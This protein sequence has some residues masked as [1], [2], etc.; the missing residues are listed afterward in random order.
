[1]WWLGIPVAVWAAKK[2]YDAVDESSSSSSYSSNDYDEKAE[3]SER[4]AKRSLAIENARVT[5]KSFLKS[6][7]VTVENKDLNFLKSPS[8][9]VGI[10]VAFLGEEERLIRKFKN[11]A[12][13]SEL[14]EAIKRA[15]IEVAKV[16]LARTSLLLESVT[17]NA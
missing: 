13:I 3:E 8:F 2:I 6:H 10:G 4:N 7:A 14:D 15:E 5:L 12:E 1:M 11:T 17:K 9:G 16:A